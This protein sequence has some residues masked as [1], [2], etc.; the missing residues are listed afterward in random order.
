MISILSSTAI[1]ELGGTNAS[2]C[3]EVRL[4][5]SADPELI[6]A[7]TFEL[8]S[9]RATM[10][11]ERDLDLNSEPDT[12]SRG[13]TRRPKQ[14]RKASTIG[15]ANKMLPTKDDTGLPG[16]PSTKVCWW[17]PAHIGFPGRIETL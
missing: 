14:P 2:T 8:S 4:R 5:Q 6:D 16:R 13:V 12:A 17:Y 11:S 9:K 10:K 7:T 1:I 3:V 15:R